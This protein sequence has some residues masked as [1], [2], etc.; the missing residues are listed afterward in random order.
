[1][2][3]LQQILLCTAAALT[4]TQ[5]AAQ[6][7]EPFAEISI[8]PEEVTVGEPVTLRVS[9][10]VPTW[11][12]KPA[13]FPSFEIPNAITRLPPN[14]SRPVSRRVG[15]DSWSGITRSYQ[16]YPLIGARFVLD[17]RDID[18]QF[19]NPGSDPIR[20]DVPTG[21]ISFSAVV[22]A[23]AEDLNP[24]VAGTSLNITRKIEGDMETLAIGDALVVTYTAELDGLSAIFLPDLVAPVDIPGIS[25]YPEQPIVE[26]GDVARRIEKLTYIFNAGGEFS[27][28]GISVDWW[29]HD[30]S[31]IETT[32]VAALQLAVEGAPLQA[33]PAGNTAPQR[34]WWAIIGAALLLLL[35]LLRLR[36]WAAKSL[37]KRQDKERQHRA[38]EPY[39]WKR[40]EKALRGSDAHRAHDEIVR[41]LAKIE[42]GF[43]SRRFS[44]RYGDADLEAELARLNRMLYAGSG[45]VPDLGKIARGLSAARQRCLAE[46]IDP[47]DVALPPLNP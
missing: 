1:M 40:A 10:F 18:V 28:P 24:Y 37:A 12:A 34:N 22:P 29:N 33:E 45:D 15:R 3:R 46:R 30:S 8:T 19:A 26:D 13:D 17:S 39:A 36:G 11:F 16:I 20:I 35:V 43:D 38:S 6:Q 25:A 21:E 7:T 31:S 4:L 32:S 9:V 42:P 47:L 27:I 14:S 23:G 5:V 44:E 41:W 2:N